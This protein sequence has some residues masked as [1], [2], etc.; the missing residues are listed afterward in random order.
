[1]GEG[2]RK[3]EEIGVEDVDSLVRGCAVLGAGG[4]GDA[5]MFKIMAELALGDTGPV[6]LVSLDHLPPEGIILPLAMVGAPMVFAE[7][8]LSGFEGVRLKTE[9]EDAL[10]KE[11]VAVMAPEIGGGNGVLPLAW[12]ARLG[13]PYA[14]ADGM[15]RAYPTIPMTT[16]HLAG[17][18]VSPAVIV[19]ARDNVLRFDTT[20]NFWAERLIRGSTTQM[21]AM[22]S[23]VLYPL[24]VADARRSTVIGSVSKA[25]RVGSLLTY[26]AEGVARAVAELDAMVL[27][28]GKVVDIERRIEYGWVRG[29]LTVE[30]SGEYRR[31]LLHI[32]IQNEN[33]V[34]MEDG[35][36]VASV[37]DIIT[38]LETESGMVISTDRLKYGQRITVIGFAADP[39]WRTP[40]GLAVGGPRAM[41]Y[42]F[43]FVPIEQIH[44]Q[45]VHA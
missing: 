10:G 5:Y 34:A 31:R 11:A 41:G 44:R 16:M 39:I 38:V 20:D 35:R 27:S 18:P 30:G 42:D 8:I 33:L 6:P 25:L 21:G 3:F 1:M 13:L 15:G 19:D 26:G 23:S 7:K 36:V 12:A 22:T 17:L 24:T 2:G 4:G 45:E 32:E 28:V 29:S 9:V 14:D 37:P 40:E 43:D